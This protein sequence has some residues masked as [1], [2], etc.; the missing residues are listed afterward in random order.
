MKGHHQVLTGAGCFI[1]AFF[2]CG[3]PPSPPVTFDIW[4]VNGSENLTLTSVK[5]ADVP[6]EE[7]A[8]QELIDDEGVA[9]NTVRLVQGWDVTPFEGKPLAVTVTGHSEGIGINPEISVTI[10]PPVQAGAVLPILVTDAP[11]SMNVRYVPL[12]SPPASKSLIEQLCSFSG[13]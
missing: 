3:C 6:P 2:L 7:K 8:T 4:L 5:I 12:E 13:F 10:E 11:F 9:V 1:A